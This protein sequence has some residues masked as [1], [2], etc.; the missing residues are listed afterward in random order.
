MELKYH[1]SEKLCCNVDDIFRG[2]YAEKVKTLHRELHDISREKNDYKGWVDY[3]E[4][5][6]PELLD[7]IVGT[8]KE[9][10]EK[11]TAFVVIGIGGS[12]VGAKAAIEALAP[13]Y[14][15]FTDGPKIYFA[16]HNADSVY[17]SNLLKRL[18]D[19]EV[20]VCIIS[21]SGST[22]EPSLAF[23][24]FKQ[25]LVEK[26]GRAG[27][28]DRIYAITDAAKGKLHDEAV[29]EGY[30]SFVIP[31]N[32]G[33]RYSVLTPVGLL[34]IAVAGIDIKAIIA[35]ARNA[36]LMY[37]C[38][39]L[40]RND[41][42]KYAVFRHFMQERGKVIEV[43]QIYDQHL[44][45]M[46]EWLKQLFG[47]SE[48]KDGKGIIPMSL[49]MSTDLHSM[50]QMLQDGRQVFFET[51]LTVGNAEEDVIIEGMEAAGRIS[52]MRRMNDV[53][54]ESALIAHADNDTP[55]VHISVPKLSPEIFGEMV[56]FFE[57][58]C[59]MSC[60]LTGV[61]PF[62]QPGVEQY[63]ANIASIIQL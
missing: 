23:E 30:K 6:E 8:A 63:K 55:H 7:D 12:F 31:D 28:N 60:M 1:L 18:K 48:C 37:N 44:G 41:C 35:G 10:R 33:G 61:D 27:A 43:L 49:Q 36:C 20:C 2:V 45:S 62:D 32:I 38:E 15:E 25:L 14:N 42:Y 21:K 34:P 58:A 39:D 19:R 16:G 3:P 59:A 50:G 26:Y 51:V 17:H 54:C 11:C 53:I 56:Y 24:L 52:T 5:I 13:Y 57:K 40:M 47:E 46:M 22:L 4:K 9:I 29:R